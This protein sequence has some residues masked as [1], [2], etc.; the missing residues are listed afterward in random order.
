MFNCQSANTTSVSRCQNVQPF[1]MFYCS[2]SWRRGCRCELQHFTRVPPP[3]V[4]KNSRLSR[5]SH[6]I[7]QGQLKALLPVDH[8]TAYSPTG[9]DAPIWGIHAWHLLIKRSK[10][11]LYQLY[12]NYG[13]PYMAKG[14]HRSELC[15]MLD[16]FQT[17][18][19]LPLFFQTNSRT[20]SDFLKFKDFSRL[21][22]NWRPVQKPCLTHAKLQSDHR[23]QNSNELL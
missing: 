23:S 3:Q 14:T 15:F 7:I 2:R 5:P 22:L 17:F 11:F 21:A 16:K 1:C 10:Q 9:T 12:S 8:T 19:G 13:R 6:S 4:I 20:F 18:Q